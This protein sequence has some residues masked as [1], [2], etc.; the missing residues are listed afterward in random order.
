M[1]TSKLLEATP[2]ELREHFLRQAETYS[3]AARNSSE[4]DAAIINLSARVETQDKIIAELKE[5][6][7]RVEALIGGG[8]R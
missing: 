5:L 3:L 1:T 8:I 2:T 6:L 7:E 4:Y